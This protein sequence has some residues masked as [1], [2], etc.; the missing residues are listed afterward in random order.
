MLSF[1]FKSKQRRTYFERLEQAPQLIDLHIVSLP[2]TISKKYEEVLDLVP[3]HWD[4]VLNVVAVF[5]FSELMLNMKSITESDKEI[6]SRKSLA[7]VKNKYGNIAI[8]YHGNYA[9]FMLD[10]GRMRPE[11]TSDNIMIIWM[12]RTFS[13]SDE[14]SQRLVEMMT[15]THSMLMYALADLMGLEFRKT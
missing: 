5:L 7:Y 10:T 2:Q 9:K 15:I 4:V 8:A 3:R 13:E 6:L 11:L 12:C 14:V 1:L